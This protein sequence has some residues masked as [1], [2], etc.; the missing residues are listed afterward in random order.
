MKSARFR[1]NVE[2]I[3]LSSGLG[4]ERVFRL[5][6]NSKQSNE[7]VR[8]VVL[9]DGTRGI[10][11]PIV[12]EDK[13]ALADALEDLAEDS[14]ERRF[15][16]NKT[17]LTEEELKLLSNPDGIDHIAFG[18]AVES[19]DDGEMLPIA[20]ARCFRDPDVPEL[21]EIAFVTADPWQ[22]LGAGAE[23]MRSLSAAA[24]RVGIRRWFAAM[25]SDNLAMKRLLDRFATKREEREI[26]GS[27]IE[28]IYDI[29]EP[30]G[31]LF[32]PSA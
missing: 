1:L 18:L 21:A 28:V 6:M 25:F 14:R 12:P 20:V 4:G 31:G 22:G 16:F 13:W 8:R 29:K 17:K 32:D 7:S 15:L 10:V 2:G 3:P 26:G 9:K 24:Y 5:T 19:G 23:L 11:R 30:A 27:V